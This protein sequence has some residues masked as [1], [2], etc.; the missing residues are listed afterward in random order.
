MRIAIVGA[1][2]IGGYFGARLIEAG[3][4]V[5]LVAR[6]AHAAGDPRARPA[7]HQRARRLDRAATRVAEDPAAL[8]VRPRRVRR[9]AARRRTRA[10]RS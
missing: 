8:G 7:H 6:G 1:G 4:Q 9:Q 10:R 3:E 5:S 2:G